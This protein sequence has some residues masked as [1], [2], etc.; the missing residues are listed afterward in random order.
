MKR[1]KG[2]SIRNDR[3]M[4]SSRSQKLMSKNYSKS[5]N[6][7]IDIKSDDIDIKC[8]DDH[9]MMMYDALHASSKT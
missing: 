4:C 7:K 1:S 5:G 9:D 2:N 8:H 6:L 3:I